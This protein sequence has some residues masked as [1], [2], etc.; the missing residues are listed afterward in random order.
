MQTT[1]KI[2]APIEQR[3]Y[4]DFYHK[5]GERIVCELCR[6]YCKLKD[7]QVGICGVNKNEGGRLKTLVYGKVSALNIDPVEKKPLYHFLPASSTL[8]LGTVGCNFRCPF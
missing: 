5:E 4:S 2:P 7:G 8:S 3:G 1:Q 6:H